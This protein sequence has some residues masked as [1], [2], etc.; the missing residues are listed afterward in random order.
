MKKLALFRLKPGS[1]TGNQAYDQ[2]DF[3]FPDISSF[4]PGYFPCANQSSLVCFDPHNRIFLG[5]YRIDLS[6]ACLAF[7]T[8]RSWIVGN[9]TCRNYSAH[10][11][12]LAMLAPE[13]QD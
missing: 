9:W 6:L 12:V 11:S 2:A 13:P 8:V 3:S 4:S 7:W 1:F 10:A 5:L